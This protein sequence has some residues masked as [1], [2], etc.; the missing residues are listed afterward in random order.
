M[1]PVKNIYYM[2]S[3]AFQTLKDQKIREVDLESFDNVQKLCAEI[4]IKAVNVQIK[5]GLGREYIPLT[6]TM[7]SVKG[8]IN[9]S[10]SIKNQ[11]IIRRQMV[12]SYDDFSINTQLNQIIKT[13]LVQL[14]RADILAAQ[15]KDI[16]KLIVFFDGVDE[17]PVHLINWNFQYSRNNQSYQ[18]I[19]AVC[20]L[21]IKGLLQTQ[22]DGTT[23]MMDFLDEQRMSRLYEKFILEYFR[24]HFPQLSASA[25]QIAWQLDSENDGMLPV[26]KSDI[27][28]QQKQ[29]VLII[30]AKYYSRNMQEQFGKQS[31]HSGNL[32][33]IFTYVKNKEYEL[34][35]EAHSVSGML[36]YAKTDEAIQPD[37][38]Y[39]MSGNRIA[40][41][42]LDL[43]QSFPEIS[44]ALDIIVETYFDV[45]PKTIS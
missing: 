40:V 27:M 22:S 25:S 8:K 37:S 41:K 42:T 13:T 28:L 9:V 12:C 11:S 39:V 44:K 3:Y 21:V 29:T 5:R 1:I 35:G 30:D 24:K 34:Q 10:E 15:K 45:I 17:L 38:E 2:L 7:S 20:Y 19:I 36:L 31:Y 32:Y 4:L 23:K 18:L 33:Q 6:E 43:N 16:R 14:L 26:M